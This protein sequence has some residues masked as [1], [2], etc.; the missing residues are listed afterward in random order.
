M[1]EG[2]EAGGGSEHLERISEAVGDVRHAISSPLT[3]ILAEVELMLMDAD[4]LNEE[5]VS[6]LKTIE[7]MAHRIRDLTAQLKTI[8]EL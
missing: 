8:A 1:A 4:D 3:A 5:Q 7:E 2:E 6:G